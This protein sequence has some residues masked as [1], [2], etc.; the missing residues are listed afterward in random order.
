[1][2]DA[3]PPTPMAANAPLRFGAFIYLFLPLPP[4]H[5]MWPPRILS[6]AASSNT[7]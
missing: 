6:E 5:S 1:M 2:D 7:S 4:D 3:S